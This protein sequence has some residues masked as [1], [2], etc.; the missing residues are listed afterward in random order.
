MFTIKFYRSKILVEDK[1][2]ILKKSQKI[3]AT[4]DNFN[5]QF[6][7]QKKPLYSYYFQQKK[8]VLNMLFKMFIAHR[9]INHI[10]LLFYKSS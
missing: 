10:L 4:D 5:R 8:E 2:F 7:Q 9:F 3:T 1:L 6:K